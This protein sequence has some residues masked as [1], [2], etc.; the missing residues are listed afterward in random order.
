MTGFSKSLKNRYKNKWAKKQVGS[1][2]S[3]QAKASMGQRRLVSKRKTRVV[4]SKK[5]SKRRF[6]RKKA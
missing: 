2:L 3:T 5:P 1:G 6:R 4:E